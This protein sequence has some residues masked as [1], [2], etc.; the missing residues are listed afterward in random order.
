QR[1][2]L[3][4]G[5]FIGNLGWRQ[6]EQTFDAVSL[7]DTSLPDTTLTYAY[8]GQVNRPFGRHSPMGRFNG[9]SHFFNA[10]YSGF[11]PA[12]RIEA[13]DYL[14]DFHQ[15]RALST[16]TYGVRGESMIALAP[17]LMA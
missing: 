10:V 3:G 4:D 9:D 1:I 15:A 16:A 13:Y 5:R 11:A 17:D 6:H 8:V 14:L 2:I 7:A 12:L